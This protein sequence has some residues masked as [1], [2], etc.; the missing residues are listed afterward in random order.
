MPLMLLKLLNLALSSEKHCLPSKKPVLLEHNKL[1]NLSRLQAICSM[2]TLL[3]RNQY[4]IR[5]KKV[6]CALYGCISILRQ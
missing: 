3:T 4:F 2:Y 1:L 5:L 6:T